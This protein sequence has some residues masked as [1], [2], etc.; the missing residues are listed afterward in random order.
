MASIAQVPRQ[1]GD[2]VSDIRRVDAYQQRGHDGAH[3]HLL[4]SS[5]IFPWDQASEARASVIRTEAAQRQQLDEIK[6]RQLLRYASAPATTSRFRPATIL[7]GVDHD[8][9]D[10]FFTEEELVELDEVERDEQ[11]G[12]VILGDDA[13]HDQNHNPDDDH[14]S[15][16]SDLCEA[17]GP[18]I[19]SKDESEGRSVISG[20]DIGPPGFATQP[21]YPEDE[22]PWKRL[23]TLEL[24]FRVADLATVLNSHPDLSVQQVLEYLYYGKYGFP[25]EA[26]AESERA[27]ESGHEAEEED[28]EE[29]WCVTDAPPP[30]EWVNRW[31]YWEADAKGGRTEGHSIR[32]RGLTG[33]SG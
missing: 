33:G 24:P 18:D 11:R 3:F 21:I 27:S 15:D 9:K 1:R 12:W 6:E 4:P 13:F 2:S 31:D 10:T 25:E 20:L 14:H 28:Q 26:P 23:T 30:C 32:C 29:D 5:V 22:S 17:S 8:A 16:F 7:K 19:E